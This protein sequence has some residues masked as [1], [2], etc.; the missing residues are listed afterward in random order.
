MSGVTNSPDRQAKK[1]PE[2]ERQGEASLSNEFV[3]QNIGLVHACCNRLKNRGVEY[4]ELFSAGCLG[5]CKAVKGFDQSRGI[6]F[7]T[8]AVPVILGEIKL[9][10]RDG[11]SIKV[12]RAL[13]ERAM[14]LLRTKQQM[15][16]ILGREPTISELSEK[17]GLSYDQT[18]EALSAAAPVLSLTVGEDGELTEIEVK[19]EGCEEN[20][21]G[22]TALFQALSHLSEGERKIIELR[23]FCG[24]TQSQ[25][26][27]K[28]GTN[29]VQISRK[30]KA[31]L[32]KLR[33]QLL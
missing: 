5:L 3:R 11:G 18:A 32:L 33:G 31:I 9:L 26:A 21:V 12:G 17:A 15:T 1:P 4:D 27:K 24:D 6:R 29:Q 23:Y 10:F 7:S 22:K 20:V 8:Y 30:E 16:V 25:A 13:K 2:K 14:H 19:E 28:L